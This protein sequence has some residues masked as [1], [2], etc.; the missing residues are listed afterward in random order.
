M[1]VGG[2]LTLTGDLTVTPAVETKE[3]DCDTCQHPLTFDD[4]GVLVCR[5]CRP[6]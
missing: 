3:L 5:A 2:K 4:N 6:L 1:K